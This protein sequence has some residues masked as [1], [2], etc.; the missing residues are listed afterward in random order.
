MKGKILTLAVAA[1]A[2]AAPMMA[3]SA[4]IYGRAQAGLEYRSDDDNAV[5]DVWDVGS[6]G[7]A[8]WGIVGSEDLGNG[9]KGIYKYE[10]DMRDASTGD[11][12]RTNQEKTRVFYVGLQGD[13]GTLTL[14]RNWLPVFGRLAPGASWVQGGRNASGAY[15]GIMGPLGFRMGNLV[16]YD[17]PKMGAFSAG[18]ALNFSNQNPGEEGVDVWAVGASYKEGPLYIGG[19]WQSET[20]AGGV[21]TDRYGINANFAFD[22]FK[23]R[24]AYYGNDTTGNENDG[25]VI[26]AEGKFDNNTVYA[27]YETWETAN[28]TVDNDQ[29][30]LLFHHHMS[31]T[32]RLFAEY[33]HCEADGDEDRDAF[34]VGFLQFWKL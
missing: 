12:S 22:A 5:D 9:L 34:E 1:A 25:W 16:T 31:K 30:R 26:G 2:A 8:R 11:N 10:W 21:D 17:L 4:E 20:S 14:G 15:A 23:I 3:Q 24:G 7:H 6:G 28:G 33:N 29:I 19:A 32:F 13:F 18:L 27:F